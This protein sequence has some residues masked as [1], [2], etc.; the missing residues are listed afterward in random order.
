MPRLSHLC[1]CACVCASFKTRCVRVFV[2]LVRQRFTSYD[3]MWLQFNSRLVAKID[4]SMQLKRQT[5][6]PTTRRQ[7][8]HLQQ[9]VSGALLTLLLLQYYTCCCCC[10]VTLA[11]VAWY[12]T[13]ARLIGRQLCSNLNHFSVCLSPASKPDLMQL[14]MW[15]T[16]KTVFGHHICAITFQ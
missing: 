16:N 1:L 8:R 14:N 6:P 4:F 5:E 2:P 9:R 7:L 12:S 3:S 15:L 10:H 13:T 11:A